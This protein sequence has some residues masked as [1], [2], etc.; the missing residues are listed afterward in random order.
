MKIIL[1]TTLTLSFLYSTDLASQYREMMRTTHVEKKVKTTSNP[2]IEKE[3]RKKYQNLASKTVPRNVDGSINMNSK[4]FKI[5]MD[6]YAKERHAYKNKPN[7]TVNS[8]KIKNDNYIESLKEI[9]AMKQDTFESSKEFNE[10]RSR[11]INTLQKRINPLALRG[12]KEFSVGTV[13]M[14][15]YDADKEAMQLSLKWNK[16][17]Q[18]IFPETKKLKI[19]SLKIPRRQAKHLFSKQ[20]IHNF[21]IAID[22]TENKIDITKIIIYD[23]SIEVK[24]TEWVDELVNSFFN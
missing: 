21:H 7:K 22:Y 9:R 8:T 17:I 11:V 19:V 5:L 12:S 13:I 16:E 14:K 4:E 24:P 1:L 2:T 15:N 18:E 20:S 10:R 3:L 6:N 23:R